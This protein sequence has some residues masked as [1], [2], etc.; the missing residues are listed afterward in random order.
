MTGLFDSLELD[1]VELF[2]QAMELER[3]LVLDLVRTCLRTLKS[4]RLQRLNA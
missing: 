3:G 4:A 2:C 1:S